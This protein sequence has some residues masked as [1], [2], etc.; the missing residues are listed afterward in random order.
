MRGG[1]KASISH[2]KN[3]QHSI[4]VIKIAPSPFSFLC[5]RLLYEKLLYSPS[6]PT[7]PLL[8]ERYSSRRIL[9]LYSSRGHLKFLSDCPPV[10]CCLRG[11]I[12]FAFRD[13]PAWCRKSLARNLQHYF[14]LSSFTAAL[15]RCHCF[16]S[17]LFC[18]IQTLFLPFCLR[19]RRSLCV[20][21]RNCFLLLH[22]R[23][24]A[25]TYTS[26]IF[27]VLLGAVAFI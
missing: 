21:T 6:A 2:F 10:L 8:A 1:D 17:P 27:Y 23:T 22:T 4:A 14:F 11:L 18:F 13:I 12:L 7:S 20:L 16:Y 15:P 5:W 26:Y 3:S 19:R 25:R 24:C 9:R